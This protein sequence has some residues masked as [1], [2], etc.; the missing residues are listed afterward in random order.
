MDVT[1]VTGLPSFKSEIAKSSC[2]NRRATCSGFL[3][4]SRSQSATMDLEP[5]DPAYV[6][7]RLSQPPFIAVDGVYNFRDLSYTT[8]VP[9]KSGLIFRSGELSGVTDE[10]NALVRYTR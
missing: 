10:G 6:L 1:L 7:E 4:T 9:V 5:L 3:A 8:T 2:S